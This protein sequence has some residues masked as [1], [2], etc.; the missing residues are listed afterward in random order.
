MTGR[1]T[2]ED[3]KMTMR[4]ALNHAIETAKV[5]ELV[6][7]DCDHDGDDECEHRVASDAADEAVA[8][9]RA[10]LLA[11]G[12]PLRYTLSD[13]GVSETITATS[14]DD[15]REQAREWAERGDWDTSRG[16]VYVSVRI[17]GED[18][19]EDSVRVSID[20]PEPE[21]SHDDGHDWQSPHE[22]VGGSEDCPG[23]LGHGGGVIISECCMHC[24]CSRTTDTWAQDRS[25]GAEGL[26]QVTYE[27]GYYLTEIA[28]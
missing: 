6:W 24:G 25:T 7:R 1:L 5:A 2:K 4:S 16:T 17:V 11:S 19:E 28:S 22:I 13:E 23:I 10:A 14:W 21:C 3:A 12:E 18:G 20:Q 15:A 26:T 9:A 8:A 27:V